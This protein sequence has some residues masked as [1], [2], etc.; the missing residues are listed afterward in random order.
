M[1][2]VGDLVISLCGHDKGSY[3]II[4]EE[5]GDFVTVCDGKRRKAACK[6]RKKKKHVQPTGMHS[7]LINTLPQHAVDSNIRREIK[8][9]K[10]L[11]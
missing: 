2:K 9:L 10:E 5:D 6:K 11:I 1:Y 8:R 3:L 4:I 7:D